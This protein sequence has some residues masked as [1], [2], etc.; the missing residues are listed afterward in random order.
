M[1]RSILVALVLAVLTLVMMR[2][3]FSDGSMSDSGSTGIQAGQTQFAAEDV[4]GRTGFSGRHKAAS[5]MEKKLNR[6]TQTKLTTGFRS[7][8]GSAPEQ[9]HTSLDGG[10]SSS[11]QGNDQLAGLAIAGQVQDEEGH[12][13]ANI[14]VLAEAIG[15]SA[16]DK[17]MGNS[18][19]EATKSTV[20]DYDGS[21][22]FGNLNG[23]EYRLHAAPLDGYAP[24][25]TN[26]RVGEVT[27]KLVLVSVREVRVYG[28]VSSSGATPLE[29]VRVIAGP[30]TRVTDSG[31]KGHYELDISIK[32]K[33]R[34]YTVHFRREGYRDQQVSLAPADL[35]DV[36][37]FE[38][39][40]SMEPLKGHT[41]VMGRLRSPDGLPFAGKILNL[42]SVKL[43]T[44]YRAQS[45]IKGD[46]SVEGVEPG[47]DYQLSVRPGAGYRDYERA[48]LEIPDDGLKLDIVLESLEEGELSGWMTDVEGQPIPGFALTLSSKTAAGQSVQ[49]VGDHQG[50]FTVDGF[51]EGSVM[52]KTNSYP[53]FEVQGIQA[54]YET[55]DPVMVVLDIGQE[56]LFGQVKNNFGDTVAAPEVTLG[57]QHNEN[58]V[59]NFS[60]RKTIADLNGNFAFTGLGHG[61]H[62][63]RVNAPGFSMAVVNVEVGLG[64]EN[65]VVELN[66]ES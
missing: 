27:A 48:Q 59:R 29:D 20:T 58:G 40:V 12:P 62:T 15:L 16:V 18:N 3:W 23:A 66:E 14:E 28:V 37:D 61:Q 45:D 32:G 26:A 35:G 56:V 65:I 41:T 9:A 43:Q 13:L 34:P 63:L 44:S 22:Y 24:A 33:N 5:S 17:P 2:V 10:A 47:A 42:R 4:N 60:M 51:P 31:S 7:S 49:V 55:D 30:P 50:F 39:D 53:F 6:S 19:T 36:F 54:S 25:E 21:F 11:S 46:F 8:A 64:A 1:T 57:W 38:L 52:L